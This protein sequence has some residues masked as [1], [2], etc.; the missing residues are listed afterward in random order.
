ME[1]PVQIEGFEGQNIVLQAAGL[2]SGTQLLV[3]GEPAAKGPKRG[4]LLLT[5]NNGDDAVVKFKAPPLD[6]IPNLIV[7]GEK[8]EVAPP[9]KWYQI[10]LALLPFIFAVAGGL[11]GI[12]VGLPAAMYNMRVFRSERPSRSQYITVGLISLASA[13][14]FLGIAVAINS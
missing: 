13:V 9:L 10:A 2:F 12:V 1:V 6:P 3:N 8:I 7:D 4:Q 14:V 5:R 11:V